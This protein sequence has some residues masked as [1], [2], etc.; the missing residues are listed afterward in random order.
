MSTFEYLRFNMFLCP[1]SKTNSKMEFFSKARKLIQNYSSIV[2]VMNFIQQSE[3]LTNYLIK[4]KDK[5]IF[6]KL[7]KNSMTD[8][9]GTYD[10]D[11][12]SKMIN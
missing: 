8:K 5:V 1:S 6:E 3:T 10:K 7:L 12:F 2:T 4:N 11:I 9:I